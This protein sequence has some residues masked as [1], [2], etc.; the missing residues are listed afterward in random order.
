MFKN[1]TLLISFVSSFYCFSQ[2]PAYVPTDSLVGWWPFN[3]N[4]NDESGNG[5]DGIVSSASLTNDR[6]GNSNR[7]YYLDGI[8][9]YIYIGD[10]DAIKGVSE[11]TWSVWLSTDSISSVEN[12]VI[13]KRIA[14]NQ[15]DYMAL[16]VT[17]YTCNYNSLRM[18]IASGN[19]NHNGA[20]VDSVLHLD[21]LVHLVA[22]FNGN[23]SNNV[24]KLKIY[25][26]GVLQNSIYRNNNSCANIAIPNLT[27]V[28]SDELYFGA[29]APNP[30]Y[31]NDV[32]SFFK[33]EI[34]DIGI[35]NRAL[36]SNEVQQLYNSSSCTYYDT[37]TI[38]DTVSISVMDT[39]LIDVTITS[40]QTPN[41]TNTIKVYPNPTN[42]VIYIDNGNYSMMSG[43]SI[44]ILNSGAQ[45]VYSSPINTQTLSLNVSQLG[46][47]GTY[48]LQILDTSMNVVEIRHI[49]LQ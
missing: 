18:S 37:V 38:Y 14:N 25:L 6:F 4:S 44:N 42:D 7:A 27:P 20:S 34:D 33:G 48:F 49:V 23:A 47:I 21:S 8:D 10:L 2:V 11:M 40:M 46:A 30:P 31:F 1:L 3:G 32:A 13:S 24:D 39:L 19:G 12:A 15:S 41:N 35:W 29:Q 28:S 22:V 16:Y 26:N 45:S 17:N 9:D 43:Y 36:D 5:N